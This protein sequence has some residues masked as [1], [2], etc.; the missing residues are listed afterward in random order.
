MTP[1]VRNQPMYSNQF[2]IDGFNATKSNLYKILKDVDDDLFVSLPSD[3]GWCI[4]EVL[5]HINK[6]SDIYLKQME[7]ALNQPNDVLPKGVGTYV[8][9][10]KMRMFVKVVSPDYKPRIKTFPVFYP[11]KKTDLDRTK[12]VEHY[13]NNM[14][15]FIAIVERS[16]SENVNVDKVM[17]RN[18]VI[19]MIKMSLSACLAINEAH[20]RRHLMQ[21][22][23]LFPENE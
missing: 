21:I 7:G 15:R 23:R 9:P 8:L 5:S 12:L 19:K 4:G 17:V 1:K 13:N 22:K 6:T 20:T 3:G 10:W 18:P 14:D 11:E 2:F 16:Q